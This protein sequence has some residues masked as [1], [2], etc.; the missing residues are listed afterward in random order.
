MTRA[1]FIASKELAE[2][3]SERN[4]T[5]DARPRISAL[6]E[7]SRQS[8]AGQPLSEFGLDSGLSSM[9]MVIRC[10]RRQAA[11]AIVNEVK[12]CTVCGGE[13]STPFR[14]G[15][16]VCATCRIKAEIAA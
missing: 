6:R 2:W 13:T 7:E 3:W 5:A 10:A 11:G 14:N 15:P 4:P 1:F 16:A 9:P 8:T 12:V